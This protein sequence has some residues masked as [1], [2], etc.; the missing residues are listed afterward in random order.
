M[1]TR[2]VHLL[3][4][5]LLLALTACGTPFARVASPSSSARPALS[6][7]PVPM[8][9]SSPSPAASPQPAPGQPEPV[10]VDVQVADLTGH[11]SD[12]VLGTL[13]GVLH[14]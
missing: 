6:Q 3:G 2:L 10:V 7:A 11:T 9:Q 13:V 1:N 5:G 8:P 12:L 14:P 4:W